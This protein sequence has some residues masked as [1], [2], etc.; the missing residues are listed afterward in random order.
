MLSFLLG[1]ALAYFVQQQFQ[2]ETST[3]KKRSPY[4][5]RKEEDQSVE[6]PD[7]L[8]N[9]LNERFGFCDFD[10]CP[11]KCDLRKFD[12]LVADWTANQTIFV[13]PPYN[14]V[15]KFMEKAVKEMEERN[16]KSVFLIPIAY[17]AKYWKSVVFGKASEIGFILERVAFK[18]FETVFNRPLCLVVFDPQARCK[19]IEDRI[20]YFPLPRHDNQVPDQS[21]VSDVGLG[22]T[23]THDSIVTAI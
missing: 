10:P 16:V 17:E 22:A 19:A 20:L 12:G 8:Y 11:Y 6:T 3:A 15:K 5:S 18:G 14:N 9:M 4:G 13:N 7:Y 21:A 23:G 1:L 2:V